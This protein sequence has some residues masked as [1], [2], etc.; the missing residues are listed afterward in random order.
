M[1]GAGGI[2]GGDGGGGGGGGAVTSVNGEVGA[3][4]LNAADV[5]ADPSGTASS[6]LAAHVGE[7]NPHT[8]Y[9]TTAAA[10][11]TYAP[12]ANPALTGT[13]TTPTPPVGATTQQIANAAFVLGEL[14]PLVRA[15]AGVEYFDHFIGS[16]TTTGDLEWDPSSNGA[17]VSTS[18]NSAAL[19]ADGVV[20]ISSGTAATGRNGWSRGERVAG[21]APFT[22]PWT[23]GVVR[24][25]WRVL[26]PVLPTGTDPTY[27]LAMGSGNLVPSNHWTE[28]VGVRIAP[29]S[30]VWTLA[31]R[32][33]GADVVG[34]VQAASIGPTAGVWQVVVLELTSTTATLYAGA[35]LAA[36]LAAGA[37]ASVTMAGATTSP[38]A[39]LFKM[40]NTAVTTTRSMSID[41]AALRFTST[42]PI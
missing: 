37:R 40:N 10:S 3:V 14:D 16:I 41:Y 17:G 1:R 20:T 13:P 4:V 38:V 35:T 21:Q 39:Q 29:G 2:E 9:L 12:I 36:A 30:A 26:I 15:S 31:S 18:K 28:G 33:L 32:T 22:T 6:A 19:G 42:T 23:R 11:S 24:L 7:A 27:S 5:G 25:A 8:Q 34:A